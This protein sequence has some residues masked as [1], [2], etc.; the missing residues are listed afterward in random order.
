LRSNKGMKKATPNTKALCDSSSIVDVGRH[1][2]EFT[3]A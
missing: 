2:A 1:Q 3:E